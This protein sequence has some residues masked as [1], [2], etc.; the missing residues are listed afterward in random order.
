MHL[1]Q[2]QKIWRFP[3]TVLKR[4]VSDLMRLVLLS[5]RPKR[6]AQAGFVLPTTVLLALMVVLTAT[7]L[8][9]R[10]FTRS[11][12]AIVQ[13]EQQVIANAATPAVDRAKAKIE[14]L[15]REDPNFP[16]GVPASD[17]LYDMMSTRLEAGKEFRGYTGR[18][19]LLV[20]GDKEARRGITAGVDPYT[21]ADETRLDINNDGILDNAWS[22]PSNG[23]TIVYSIL[24]DD[25]V[26]ITEKATPPAGQL[27]RPYVSGSLSLQNEA[28][29]AKAD[30][31][32]TRTGPLATTEASPLCKGAVAEAGWQVVSQGNAS[33]LQKNFQINAF[34]ANADGGPG[35]T[36]ETL[37]F[38]Q[39]RQAARASKWG[40]WFRYDLEIFPGPA[41]NWNGA[42][43]TDGNLLVH[44]DSVQLHM[45]SSH[46]SCVYGQESS[47]ISLSEFEDTGFQGQ[48]IQGTTKNDKY[49]NTKPSIHVYNGANKQPVTNLDLTSANHSVEKGKPSDIAVN[50]MALFTQDRVQHMNDPSVGRWKR[51]AGWDTAANKFGVQSGGARV[52]NDVAT[53]PFVDDFYRADN[54]WGPKP[55]YDANTP[56]YDVAAVSGRTI[57][58]PVVGL[59]G[60]TDEEQGLDGY[61]ERQ[62]IKSGLRLIVG[63]RLELGNNDAWNKDPLVT[64]TPNPPTPDITGTTG[65]NAL[66]PSTGKP[67]GVNAR[68]GGNHE[69]L[70]RRSL[71][72]NLAAV[73]GMV[74]YHYQGADPVNT[75]TT[76]GEFP[77]ACVA[78]TAHPGT[79][80]SIVNSRTF[81]RYNNDQKKVR[82]DFLNGQ[83]T[84]GW[85]F[86]YPIAFNTE[87]RFA[88]QLRADKPLGIALRN[89]ANFAGDP[90]GGAPSFKAF[91]DN[92]IHPFPYHSMWGDFSPLR[93]VLM[94]IDTPSAPTTDQV[95]IERYTALSFADKATLHSAACTLSMLAYNIDQTTAEY[96]AM[97]TNYEGAKKLQ[98]VTTGGSR[99][100]SRITDYLVTR[101]DPKDK[102]NY[103]KYTGN[104]GADKQ[105]QDAL[106]ALPSGSRNKL[107]VDPNPNTA[108]VNPETSATVCAAADDGPNFEPACDSYEF[109][110]SLT[111]DDW[112]SL[113]RVFASSLKEPDDID[114]LL[115]VRQDLVRVNS[116]LRDRDLG[117]RDEPSD[118]QLDVTPSGNNVFWNSNNG[119]TGFVKTNGTSSKDGYVY[120]ASCNPNIFSQVAAGGGGGTDNVLLGAM[121]ACVNLEEETMPVRYPSLFYLFPLV[122]HG[123]AGNVG[124]DN[125]QPRV[126]SGARA[127]KPD[128]T[129]VIPGDPEYVTQTSAYITSNYSTYGA[130]APTF[131]VVQDSATPDPRNGL[132]LIAASPKLD[133]DLTKWTLPVKALTGATALATTNVNDLNKAFQIDYIDSVGTKK[134]LR[135]PFLDKGIFDGREQLNLRV[136][137]IDLELLTTEKVKTGTE[138]DFW[139]TSNREKQ[140]EGVVFA[141]REDAVREDE[142]V[143]PKN[144]S[145]SDCTG[146]TAGIT[147]GLK[148]ETVDVCQMR[149]TSGTVGQDPP[150]TAQGISIKPV[151]FIPDPERRSYGFRLRTFSGAPADFSGT[152]F[153]RDMGMTFVT[154]NSVYIQGDLNPHSEDGTTSKILEEF[155]QTLWNGN[156]NFGN[157]FYN[158]RTTLNTAKF[159]VLDKDHWRPVELL[160][161]AITILSNNF[162]DGAVE[163]GILANRPNS[164]GAATSSYMNQNRPTSPSTNLVRSQLE[165]GTAANTA[166]TNGS[167][168]YVDR[169]G[170][171]HITATTP[172]YNEYNTN[173]KW[174]NFDTNE[175]ERRRNL[176]TA[177][178]TFVNA[179]FV[180]GIV[181]KRAK[182]SYGGLHNYPRFIETWNG[183]NLFI[184]GSF[185][186]LNFS[187]GSTGPFEQDAWEADEAPQNAEPIGYYSPPNR[188]WGYDVGLLY[189]PPAP[190]ARRFVTIGSPRS[191]YYRELPA[192]DPYVV[193]LRCAK[194]KDGNLI[195]N[196]LCPDPNKA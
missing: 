59:G 67:S 108:V 24:V 117:F 45:V 40:A 27:K 190:A 17:I 93:R 162:K 151:D 35:Q 11:E 180:G 152:S 126:V 29:Q 62:A 113:I 112:L 70:Q 31:L 185:I 171:Y 149:V 153:A 57:G 142:I 15:F 60:V 13:R 36:F 75:T 144:A 114:A 12:Q 161:D 174:T 44:S 94:Q 72:D 25:A 150:L 52:V 53:R 43:H 6:M 76:S 128:G 103:N 5:N 121:I 54:R 159:T 26:D 33:S 1:H 176:Q 157:D 182:Q 22:F 170:T 195:L 101:Q 91:Q 145:A 68:F 98:S 147:Y 14:F 134:S 100:I 48:I 193:N 189:L 50:A 61:W 141:F 74:V 155:T 177:D 111:F 127:T 187:T 58:D 106:A 178:E 34:V 86:T 104:T 131:K 51:R 77:A 88:F 92:A 181:P 129:T 64:T 132:N 66:Y 143:R 71:Q 139:L 37:E 99:A 97:L 160:S 133:T 38:Q 19:P 119:L 107:W 168:P 146:L 78:M 47:E 90:G 73:Q 83:G 148:I 110:N 122:D 120:G 42:M 32:V 7:A 138:P 69:Y 80:Q 164:E 192:D 167:P 4:L 102:K 123:I 154:D 28:N 105:V 46:N 137:D 175:G 84:N 136:L 179:T 8:T 158:K 3:K 9:Y 109:F 196:G 191:E 81:A 85:E 156:V 166:P 140:A 172:F 165:T 49:E 173:A 169:N 56:Q 124:T 30:S 116:L 16:S 183:K 184:S 115:A 21:L 89:L 55:R 135:V 41:F 95:A 79:K 10:T 186:Q 39:S 82:V 20:G 2:L 118:E 163:D 18:V 130:T 96:E 87:G 194:D 125:E 65:K 23:Q 188:R 63:Q